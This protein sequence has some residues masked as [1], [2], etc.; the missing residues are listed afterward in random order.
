MGDFLAAHGW[1]VALMA[2]LL[3]ASALFSGTETAL[4]CLT[5]GQLHRLGRRGPVGRLVVSLM[6]R[7][8]GVLNTLLLGNMLANVAYASVAAVGLLGLRDSGAA[9]WAIAM[10][11]AV[12]LLALILVGEVSPKMLA[13]VL[14]ER[15]ALAAAP[16]LAVLERF[17]R[18]LLWGLDSVLVR[19]L[20]TLIAPPGPEGSAV[21]GE[22]LAAVL[23]L[24]ARRGAIDQDT[25]ALLQEIVE[26]TGLKA[27]DVMVPRV[28]V[29]A[30]DVDAPA[31][32]LLELFRKRRLRRIPVYERDVDRIIGVVHA[33]RLLLEPDAPLRDMVAA[34]P[35]VPEAA[36]L[37]RVLLQFRVTRTQMGVVVDEYG[38]TAG[39]I[40]LQDILEE[41]VG[42]LPD[43]REVQ[44]ASP[45]VQRIGP[46]AYL[47]D[48]NLAVHEWRDAFKIDLGGARIS[49]I[50]GFVV[51][52]LGRIPRVQDTV[53][54]R[55]LRFTVQTMRRRRIGKLRL[56]LEEAP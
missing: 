10:A 9:P 29:I 56:D 3:G 22:E 45:A 24:S 35:F 32:G 23:D 18:P 6:R 30:Y 13:L 17:F 2:A 14:G 15:W 28:D 34:V 52:L 31:H 43:P 36:N 47:L 37:E 49:T 21:T 4:F 38:G 53:S 12:P 42:E 50:G 11:S 44:R 16:P 20:T 55:N 25:N 40:T 39:L 1:Q 51:S 33:R 48:G 41:I 26:L 46:A 5:R 19:P 7:P 54:Y 27:A 8:G